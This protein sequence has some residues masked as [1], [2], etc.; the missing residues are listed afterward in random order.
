MNWRGFINAAF[1][2]WLISNPITFGYQNPL[3]LWNDVICGVLAVAFGLMTVK[4]NHYAWGTVVIGVWLQLAPLCL[5]KPEVVPFVNDTFIGLLLLIF[6]LIIPDTPG[7]FIS[8]ASDI[9]N[10]WSYNPSSYIQRGPIIA[11]NLLCFLIARYLTVYQLG[12]IDQIWDPF[13]GDGTVKVLTSSVSQAFPISDAG[14]GA[15]CYLLETIL[16]FGNS[17]RWHTMP[18]LVVMFGILAV[19][20]SC[21]S[22]T[23][24]ILQ[25]TI[26]GAW[27]S[28]CI[29][30]AIL[31]LFVIPLS[32]DE[33]IATVSFLKQCSKRGESPWKVLWKGSLPVQATDSSPSISRNF[34]Q[35]TVRGIT[36]PWNLL[37]T[38]LGGVAA[39][40]V[41]SYVAGALI[42]LFSVISWAEVGRVFRYL[43]IPLSIVLCFSNL[44]LG[45]LCFFCAWRKGAIKEKYGVFKIL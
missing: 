6:S 4:K 13:F 31:M 11:L 16:A 23:L 43:I 7:S 32:L 18:W 15:I 42:I 24:I 21:V 34:L 45:V 19:P 41:G 2:L 12:F 26:V 39:M 3:H 5:G 25:P 38:A 37:L 10:G 29:A 28:L 27:C 44:I 30:T 20:V 17:Q 14:L 33:V 9:P 35:E 1:G 8:N 36:I 22:I 40:I